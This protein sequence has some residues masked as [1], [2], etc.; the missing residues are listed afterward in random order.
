MK[1]HVGDEV[2]ILYCGSHHGMVGRTGT[3]IFYKFFKY[4]VRVMLTPEEIESLKGTFLEGIKQT[5]FVLDE[6]EIRRKQ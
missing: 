1:F 2:E 5:V 6:N 3:V 4:D